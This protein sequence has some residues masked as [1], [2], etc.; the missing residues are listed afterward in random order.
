[1]FEIVKFLQKHFARR[2][3]VED[4]ITGL[5]RAFLQGEERNKKTA[6]GALESGGTV[7]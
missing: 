3:V 5:F 2:A 7:W 1:M 6:E 4:K